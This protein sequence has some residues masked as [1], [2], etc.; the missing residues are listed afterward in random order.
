MIVRGLIGWFACFQSN[1]SITCWYF[2]LLQSVNIHPTLLI[3]EMKVILNICLFYVRDK[4]IVNQWFLN[5]HPLH[6][7][8]PCIAGSA[9]RC[10]ATI[11]VERREKPFNIFQKVRKTRCA[12]IL[13]KSVLE[14]LGFLHLV[15]MKLRQGF[16]RENSPNSIGRF[17]LFLHLVVKPLGMNVTIFPWI[18]IQKSRPCVLHTNQKQ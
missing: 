12:N 9:S 4:T 3:N 6:I 16:S 14:K 10:Q 15:L 7:L 2:L 1:V 13:E 18:F 8:V 5:L 17:V 11:M